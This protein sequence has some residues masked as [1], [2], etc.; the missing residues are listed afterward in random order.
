M[1]PGDAVRRSGV[2]ARVGKYSDERDSDG[3]GCIRL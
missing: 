1:I 2:L 3:K